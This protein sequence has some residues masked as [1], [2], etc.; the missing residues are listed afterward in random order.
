MRKELNLYYKY[1]HNGML[2]RLPLTTAFVLIVVWA[3]SLMVFGE[4]Q[5]VKPLAVVSVFII[6][7]ISSLWS[8]LY[9][10]NQRL[11]IL[12][13][14]SSIVMD[15]SP[16]YKAEFKI[17]TEDKK[18]YIYTNDDVQYRYIIYCLPIGIIREIHKGQSE[19][20]ITGEIFS[21]EDQHRPTVILS[22]YGAIIV[23]AQAK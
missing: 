20:V 21:S 8:A 1:N 9:F 6:I 12:L 14:K 13:S 2:R 3:I 10:D 5:F 16:H 4:G 17:V 22:S 7:C 18:R 19:L 23:Q 11:L 15:T